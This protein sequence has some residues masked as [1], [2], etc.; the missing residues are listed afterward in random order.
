MSR[1]RAVNVIYSQSTTPQGGGIHS[2]RWGVCRAM[3]TDETYSPITTS[4]V[5]TVRYTRQ[6]NGWHFV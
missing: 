4:Q 3:R 6:C 5:R 2:T 1:R